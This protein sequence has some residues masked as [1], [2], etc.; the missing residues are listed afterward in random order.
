MVDQFMEEAMCANRQIWSTVDAK[1]HIPNMVI[2]PGI[3][4]SVNEFFL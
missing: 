1:L 2:L 3:S 4:H